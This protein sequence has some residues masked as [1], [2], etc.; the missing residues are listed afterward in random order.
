MY[1][2]ILLAIGPLG[3]FI[4]KNHYE[5]IQ[6]NRV[7]STSEEEFQL[8]FTTT[9]HDDRG[10]RMRRLWHLAY[11]LICNPNLKELRR[12]DKHEYKATDGVFTQQFLS[13]VSEAGNSIFNT[14]ETKNKFKMEFP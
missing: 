2:C 14:D 5:P 3:R 11:T 6:M 9:D 12:R 8:K 1:L 13:T 10:K 7:T 4:S